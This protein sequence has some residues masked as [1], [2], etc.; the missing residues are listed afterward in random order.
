MNDIKISELEETNFLQGGCC[1]P[2]V[3]E[4]ETKKVSF[5]TLKNELPQTEVMV[6]NTTT[7]EPGTDAKV[8]NSGTPTNPLLNFTIPRGAKGDKGEQG[9]KGDKGDKGDPGEV[10]QVEFDKLKNTLNVEIESLYAQIPQGEVE[11]S[12]ISVQDS[13]N[14]PILQLALKGKSTQDGTPT[15]D[16]PIDIINVSGTNLFNKNDVDVNYRL[17]SSGNLYHENGYNTSKFIKVEP[18][19][20]YCR[21]I[22]I[23][24]MEPVCTYDKD[25]TFIRRIQSGTTFTTSDTE[26]YIKTTASNEHLNTMQ[27]EKGTVSHDYIMYGCIQLKVSN[28]DNT[29]IKTL[30]IDLKDNELCSTKDLSVCDEIILENEKIYLKK[31]VGKVIL[32]G[33]ENWSLFFSTQGIFTTNLTDRSIENPSTINCMSDKFVGATRS[34]IRYGLES[35][36]NVCS[37]FAG[38]LV[39]AL[40]NISSVE[41]FKSWL[42]THNVEVQYVLAEPETIYLG[43]FAALKTYKNITKVNNSETVEMRLKYYKDIETLI[44]NLTKE[45]NE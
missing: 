10:T 22:N 30:N 11:G 18:N 6:G 20:N 25:K 16:N 23:V 42:S 27:V 31:N 21:N 35:A 17:D 7:S 37:T 14:L 32:D 9:P 39:I 2:L 33:S 24:Q 28:N 13:S 26:V 43:A 3:Q 5:E 15:P 4:N 41:E 19:T 34:S 38:E 36:N 44:N 45:V 8:F 40:K 29:D 1:F 12:N